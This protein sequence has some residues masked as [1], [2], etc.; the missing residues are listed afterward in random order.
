M[1]Y[2]NS[3]EMQVIKSKSMKLAT[4]DCKEDLTDFL[5]S[6]LCSKRKIWSKNELFDK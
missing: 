3:Y 4:I 5:D 1:S 2:N 6:D